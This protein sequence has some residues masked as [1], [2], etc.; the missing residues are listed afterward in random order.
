MVASSSIS[1]MKTNY[2]GQKW[3]R[4]G[5]VGQYQQVKQRRSLYSYNPHENGTNWLE[6]T[7]GLEPTT[8]C[9]GG[10]CSIH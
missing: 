1:S 4:I 6:A 8:Y 7:V 9:L 2:S 5:G 3:W 10:S